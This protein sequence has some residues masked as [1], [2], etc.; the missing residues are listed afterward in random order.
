MP[1][2]PLPH[3]SPSQRPLQHV[4]AVWCVQKPVFAVQ[5]ACEQKDVTQPVSSTTCI[6]AAA[7]ISCVHEAVHSVI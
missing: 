2:S 6:A 3:E 1:H 5:L 7:V 4:Y